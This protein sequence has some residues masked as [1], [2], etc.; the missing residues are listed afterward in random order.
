MD[1]KARKQRTMESILS[2]ISSPLVQTLPASAELAFKTSFKPT[3]SSTSASRSVSSAAFQPS[4]ERSCRP[5]CVRAVLKRENDP[6]LDFR[7]GFLVSTV[8]RAFVQEH[9]VSVAIIAA[10]SSKRPVCV[11]SADSEICSSPRAT[12]FASLSLSSCL[13]SYCV[14]TSRSTRERTG[15]SS[16]WYLRAS[17]TSLVNLI[18]S[19]K[20]TLSSPAMAMSIAQ[21]ASTSSLLPSSSAR[22]M[23]TSSGT[24]LHRT[25]SV[26]AT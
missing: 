20:S 15:S 6:A 23:Y 22:T 12:T 13:Y 24:L 17:T 9:D 14:L 19:D 26:D 1:S 7:P 25:A 4:T 8:R 3:R 18:A 21:T 5:S 16:R 10:V 11:S 2:L